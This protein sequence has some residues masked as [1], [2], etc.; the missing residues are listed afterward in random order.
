MKKRRFGRGTAGLLCA[1]LASGLAPG[2]ALAGD[3]TVE[4]LTAPYVRSAVRIVPDKDAPLVALDGTDVDYAEPLTFL[5]TGRVKFV[6]ANY[7]PLTVQASIDAVESEDPS[8]AALE[9]F[10]TAFYKTFDPASGSAKVFAT[11]QRLRE[12][13]GGQV[14]DTT[15][16]ESARAEADIIAFDLALRPGEI[17]PSTVKSWVDGALG[18]EGAQAQATDLA[19]IGRTLA[20][21]AKAARPPLDR[22][23]ELREL[24]PEEAAQREAGISQLKARM[25]SADEEVVAARRSLAAARFAA[26]ARRAEAEPSDAKTAVA[27]G[28]AAAQEV[29]LRKVEAGAQA[30]R[31]AVASAQQEAECVRGVLPLVAVFFRTEPEEQLDRLKRLAQSASELS[32]SLTK[33]AANDELWYPPAYGP[34]GDAVANARS[35]DFVLD[36]KSVKPGKVVTVTVSAK[37]TSF[38]IDDGVLTRT[39]VP[40][41]DSKTV[42]RLRERSLFAPELGAGLVVASVKTPTYGAVAN[43]AGETVVAKVKVKERDFKGALVLNAV[44]RCWNDSFLYPMLQF[45]LAADESAPAIFV[46]GGFRFIRPKGF[47]LSAGVVL[48]WVK[49]L[50]GLRIGEAVGSQAL[51][52]ADLKAQPTAKPYFALHYSF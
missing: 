47:G 10:V 25:S 38:V 2:R 18:R 6:V 51:I 12:Q 7:N 14:V 43:D 35:K 50:D 24:L 11:A 15:C 36:S 39:P 44:C 19:T 21:S 29:A 42:F 40:K 20:D 8:Y 3:A 31:K 23:I 9:K 32:A 16:P 13:A 45:G 17:P 34:F 1:S 48:A 30:A 52:D 27:A 37:R 4:L 49:D 28:R 33:T 41:S 5:A 46:G 26:R 22:L